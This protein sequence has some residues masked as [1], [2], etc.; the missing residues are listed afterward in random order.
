MNR[1][2]RKALEDYLAM[3]EAEKVTLGFRAACSEDYRIWK[4]KYGKNCPARHHAYN[5]L[6]FRLRLSMECRTINGKRK[7]GVRLN[8]LPTGRETVFVPTGAFALAESG[9]YQPLGVRKEMKS[10][11]KKHVLKKARKEMDS[12][13]KQI[14]PHLLVES[15]K[16]GTSFSDAMIVDLKLNV[17][18]QHV[19][20]LY[21]SSVNAIKIGISSDVQ[22][23]R[24]Q[25]ENQLGIENMKV[26]GWVP[27]AGQKLEA[28]LHKLF[29]HLRTCPERGKEWFRATGELKGFV[30]GLNQ[31]AMKA[32]FIEE[33][34]SK[35]SR[36]GG[37]V[38][39]AA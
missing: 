14:Y 25:I 6:L 31:T 16:G 37:P 28:R 33:A 24:I 12:S 27:Y 15:V 29:N 22:R 8:D 21:D 4:D 26:V 39:E 18:E 3:P 17:S 23:R 11:Y 30:E 34:E 7:V 13:W 36:C 1:S 38:V 9:C 2:L 5:Y 35:A 32:E 10:S 19:Y 20:F